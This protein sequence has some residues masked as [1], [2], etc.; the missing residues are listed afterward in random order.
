MR[1]NITIAI[2]L[3]LLFLIGVARGDDR[4]QR[5]EHHDYII[6]RQQAGQVSGVPTSCSHHR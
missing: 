6:E 5:R 2:L 4:H 3:W 1:T